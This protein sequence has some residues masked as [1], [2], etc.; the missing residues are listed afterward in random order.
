[1]K[2]KVKTVDSFYNESDKKRLESIGFKFD[3]RNPEFE[4][5]GPW[6]KLSFEPE[7]EINSLEELQEFAKTHGDIILGEKFDSIEI[8][9]DYKE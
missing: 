5:P 4:F 9:D 8:Y 3:E 6:F 1:M 2:F 7:I